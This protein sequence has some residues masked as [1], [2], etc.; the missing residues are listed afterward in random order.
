MA[1]NYSAVPLVETLPGVSSY[2]EMY[3]ESNH[4]SLA[5]LNA[6]QLPADVEVQ[7]SLTGSLK[8]MNPV[9]MDYDGGASCGVDDFDKIDG[10]GDPFLGPP[11]ASRIARFF[12]VSSTMTTTFAERTVKKPKLRDFDDE[13]IIV[14]YD[15]GSLSDV[16]PGEVCM[17]K[18]PD[19]TPPMSLRAFLLSPHNYISLFDTLKKNGLILNITALLVYPPRREPCLCSHIGTQYASQFVAF[20]AAYWNILVSSVVDLINFITSINQMF[21]DKVLSELMSYKTAKQINTYSKAAGKLARI[22]EMP[23][24]ESD[25]P[26]LPRRVS[27]M[28]G[29]DIPDRFSEW[30]AANP[31]MGSLHYALSAPSTIFHADLARVTGIN[32]ARQRENP[33][34][35][36]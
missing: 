24:L 22:Q 36:R 8:G 21:A 18:T 2:Q 5:A 33:T 28:A 9:Y 26:I 17:C 23:Q 4:G 34:E 15:I 11:T 12:D 30:W 27:T 14:G 7:L 35:Y 3:V 31:D 25:T 29:S 32:Y 6:P 16:A 20:S 10:A 1:I 19:G 13:K